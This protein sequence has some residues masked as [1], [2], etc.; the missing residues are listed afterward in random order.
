MWL[1][2]SWVS[3]KVGCAHRDFSIHIESVVGGVLKAVMYQPKMG[4]VKAR[5]LSVMSTIM[6]FSSTV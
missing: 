6:L 4:I 5:K 1:K 3:R 2:N